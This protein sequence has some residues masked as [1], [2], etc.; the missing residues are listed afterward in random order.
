MLRVEKGSKM[1]QIHACRGAMSVRTIEVAIA[2]QRRKAVITI[3]R[4]AINGFLE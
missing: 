1:P 2:M 3:R 4:G